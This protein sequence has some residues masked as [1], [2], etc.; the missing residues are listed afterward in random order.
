MNNNSTR[1]SK[2]Q[3]LTFTRNL[4]PLLL[5]DD[6]GAAATAIQKA[7]NLPN[8]EETDKKINAALIQNQTDV[9]DRIFILEGDRGAYPIPRATVENY[10]H[11]SSWRVETHPK[12]EKTTTTTT[13][14]FLAVSPTRRDRKC[15]NLR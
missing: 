1:D 5:N 8:K 10:S 9:M 14:T 7:S 11:P 2:Y 4:P 3:S 15:L 12:P 6:E 13:I